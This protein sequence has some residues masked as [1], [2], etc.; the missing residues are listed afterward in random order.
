M[1]RALRAACVDPALTLGAAGLGQLI[2]GSP[3]DLLVVPV[4]GLREPG[5]RGTTLA[6]T[7]PLA[8]IVAGRV[9]HRVESFDP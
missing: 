2:R 8:T 3:A 5:E 4:D 1:W 7:R 9:V 6:A